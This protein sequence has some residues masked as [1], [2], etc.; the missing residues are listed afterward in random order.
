MEPGKQLIAE[1]CSLIPDLVDPEPDIHASAEYRKDLCVTYAKRV[2]GL[3]AE[4]AS[5]PLD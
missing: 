1:C 5:Q 3:A 2:L 4:R